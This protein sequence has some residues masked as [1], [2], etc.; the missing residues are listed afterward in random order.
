MNKD[1]KFYFYEIS[2]IPR[3]SGNEGK[4]KEYLVNFANE[5]KLKY[6]I[7][8]QNNV[9]IWKKANRNYNNSETIGLQAHVD[10]VCEKSKNNKHDFNKEPIEVIEKDGFLKA[11]GTTLG[12]DNGIGVAYILAI[13]DSTIM[14]HPNIEAIFTTQ[15]ETTMNGVKYLD[16][17]KILSKKIISFDNFN[18]KEIW[19]GSASSQEWYTEIETKIIKQENIKTYKLSLNNFIGGHAGMDIGDTKRGNPIKVAFDILKETNVYIN[20]VKAGSLIN[21][22]P[23]ECEIIFSVKK[24]DLKSIDKIIKNIKLKKYEYSIE[25]IE[26]KEIEAQIYMMNDVDSRNTINC[27]NE[28]ENGAIYR[29]NNQNVIVG[30]NLSKVEYND[31]KININFCVRGNKRE[32]TD[33]Y[34]K[35]LEENIIQKYKLIINKYDEWHGYE[36]SIKNELIKVCQDIYKRQTNEIP[37]IL[38]VQA[39][40]ECEFLGLKIKD[41]QYVALGTNTFDV[42]SINERIEIKSIERTWKIILEIL[43]YYCERS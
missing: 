21:I 25:N 35:K 42:H 37:N 4:I 12:A 32:L 36:Q 40:L 41:L 18:E 30:A 13:L 9:I 29:D 8:E 17:S 10:M 20:C 39:C 7:D 2:K 22:I 5:R 28:F 15:E 16:E 6:Y 23:R 3:K 19:I 27:I 33:R 43:N 1:W 26:I 14:N 24:E 38:G 11:N 31:G 34:I